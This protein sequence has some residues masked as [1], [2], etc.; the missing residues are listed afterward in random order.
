MTFQLFL[1]ISNAQWW[2]MNEAGYPAKERNSLQNPIFGICT[3]PQCPFCKGMP[4]KLHEFADKIGNKTNVVFTHFDSSKTYVC[5]R[6]KIHGVPTFVLIRSQ[7]SRFWTKT[8]AREPSEWTKFLNSQLHSSITQLAES[9]DIQS[10]I[11]K[12]S[13][14]GSM[15][16]LE[17]KRSD[18]ALYKKYQR[19]AGRTSYLMTPFY[20]IDAPLSKPRITAVFSPSCNLSQTIDPDKIE[21][22]VTKHF[23]SFQ[24]NYEL[25]DIQE[26]GVK[27]PLLLTASANSMMQSHRFA[28]NKLS[29]E[30]CHDIQLGWFNTEKNKRILK[31]IKREKSEAPFFVGINARQ[32]CLM[33]SKDRVLDV[34]QNGF[35][36]KLLEGVNCS[37]AKALKIRASKHKPTHNS[38]WMAVLLIPCICFTLYMALREEIAKLE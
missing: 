34:Q 6:A 38:P 10:H 12:L 37:S 15:I 26:V 35:I 36:P 17:G 3:S 9:K 32:N 23:R 14:G 27:K 7:R 22:F 24:Y 20:F 8:N 30:F 19:A 31:A 21:S 29:H 33:I 16:V 13:S 18:K 25:E 11:S 5:S 2:D 1:Q 4:E 28:I